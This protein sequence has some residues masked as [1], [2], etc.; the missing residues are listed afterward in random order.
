MHSQGLGEVEEK[1]E[2]KVTD[3]MTQQLSEHDVGL[4]AFVQI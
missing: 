3:W 1:N 2:S 4:L